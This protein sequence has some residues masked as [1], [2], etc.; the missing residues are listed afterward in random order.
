MS[1]RADALATDARRAK[2]LLGGP[3]DAAVVLGSGLSSALHE[4][5]DFARLPY[6]KLQGMPN[7]ALSGHAGELL[8]GTLHGKRVLVFAGRVHLYQGFTAAQVTY[9]V[10]LAHAA[11][12]PVLVLT[13]AA[14]ALDPTFVPGDLMLIA[15]HLNLTGANPLVGA[16]LNDPFVD[17]TDAYSPRLRLL[18]QRAHTAPRPLH[19]GV[20]AGVLGP[21]YETAAE[22]RFLN[23]IGADAVG[24]ST[25]LETIAARARGMEVLGVSLI[26]NTVGAQDTSH[27]DVTR[28][29]GTAA[30]QLAGLLEG[31]IA[32]LAQ[33]PD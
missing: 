21:S 12:A 18:A 25:V 6:A 19:E 26:T 15:D 8:G 22:A 9:S 4:R 17:M 20:Y 2:K 13:N 3:A 32:A 10:A 14:G 23:S 28:V 16:G 11:G 27:A 29:A 30:A 5:A 31:V 24:M 1:S 33:T 7:A